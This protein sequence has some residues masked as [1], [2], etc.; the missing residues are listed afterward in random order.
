M[1]S[2]ARRVFVSFVVS[3]F[4]CFGST[5]RMGF[6]PR[7]CVRVTFPFGRILSD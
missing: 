7:W 5:A 2:S 1:G 3:P 4:R 6:P